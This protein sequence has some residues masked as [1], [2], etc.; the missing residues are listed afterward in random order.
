MRKCFVIHLV[1]IKFVTQI[2]PIIFKDLL[3]S[4]FLIEFFNTVITCT[5]LLRMIVRNQSE[6]MEWWL[7]KLWSEKYKQDKIIACLNSFLN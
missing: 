6:I 7:V 4:F 5:F 1:Y 3:K 2:V